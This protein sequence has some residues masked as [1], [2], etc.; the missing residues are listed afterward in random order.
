[1]TDPPEG[2]LQNVARRQSLLHNA[3]LSEVGH[4]RPGMQPGLPL[5]EAGTEAAKIER[6]LQQQ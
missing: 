3:W 1:M 5:D 2:F 6:Q 4:E